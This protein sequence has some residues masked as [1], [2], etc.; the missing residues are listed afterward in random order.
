MG[1]YVG[2]DITVRIFLCGSVSCEE[3]FGH[4]LVYSEAI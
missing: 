3:F 2:G 1:I 4:H